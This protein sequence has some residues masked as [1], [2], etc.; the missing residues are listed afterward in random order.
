M[1]QNT[2][3]IKDLGK[4]TLTVEGDY[5][6]KVYERISMVK[7][8]G[9]SY[10]SKKDVP[11][12][13]LPTDNDYWMQLATGMSYESLEEFLKSECYIKYAGAV[14]SIDDLPTVSISNKGDLYIIESNFTIIN[15]L[16][17]I[18]DGNYLAGGMMLNIGS[19]YIPMGAKILNDKPLVSPTIS[20]NWTIRY[21]DNIPITS[22][23]K[24][25]IIIKGV[26]VDLQATF[27][28][29]HDDSKKDPTKG[30]WQ[31]S[32]TQLPE[33][34][35]D[36]VPL[37]IYGIEFDNQAPKE[38]D[39]RLRAPKIGLVVENNRVV[40][41]NATDDDVT[42]DKVSVTFVDEILYGQNTESDFNSFTDIDS[43]GFLI[44]SK[45]N[46]NTNKF[47]IYNVT[48]DVDKYYIV[49]YKSSL[50]DLT[51][52]IMNDALDVLSAFDKLNHTV[53]Y[54]NLAGYTTH[55]KVYISGNKGAFTDVKL[56][57]K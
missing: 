1:S 18:V 45:A 12:N 42:S 32:T 14:Q 48:S 4:V 13:V 23:L 38:Y 25:L 24:D 51:H 8:E 15:N 9:N 49:A 2:P 35:I 20:P 31:G 50:P 27:K 11:S 40:I 34:N 52:I 36:S 3:I 10:I 54:T 22:N 5:V 33:S 41:P 44:Q 56:E 55:Y 30:G 7:Y 16:I 37:N 19:M 28:W 43:F 17:P 29:I 57:F 47:T 46:N 39:A 53:S 6:N 26:V 21:G